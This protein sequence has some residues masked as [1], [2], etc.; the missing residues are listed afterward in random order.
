MH[1]VPCV[2]IRRGLHFS[3]SNPLD[4][5]LRA[6]FYPDG[7]AENRGDLRSVKRKQEAGIALREAAAAGSIKRIKA[8]NREA[9]GRHR[10]GFS[11]FLSSRARLVHSPLTFY[12]RGKT[13]ERVRARKI[14]HNRFLRS[15]ASGEKS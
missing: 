10:L 5:S 8:A 3:A 15:K 4:A 7:S 13:V 2:I 12:S 14:S 11:S 6:R 1:T 9:K